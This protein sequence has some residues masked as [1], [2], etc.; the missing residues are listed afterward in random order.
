MKNVYT[1]VGTIYMV[2]VDALL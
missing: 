1:L 2:Q